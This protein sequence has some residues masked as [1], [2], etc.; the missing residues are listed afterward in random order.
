MAMEILCGFFA[1]FSILATI[2][3]SNLFWLGLREARGVSALLSSPQQLQDIVNVELLSMPSAEYAMYAQ[4]VE[5]GY[6]FNMQ[7]FN[8]ADEKA[9]THG[10]S[11]LRIMLVVVVIG[12]GV[13]GFVTFG[14]FALALPIINFLIVHATFVG[15]L[16]GA[17]GNSAYAR[18]IQHVQICALILH[19]WY[20]DNPREASTWLEHE[21]HL[22]P[23]EL[24]VT[25]L[26]CSNGCCQCSS[27]N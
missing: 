1:V 18:A 27:A 20:A 7:A 4:P 25:N 23:L 13:L 10:R 2:V 12:S 24:L 16:R 5:P 3:L 8:L 14:W 22:K 15:S 6:G 11:L 26:K 19:R 21:P 9:Q 17:I